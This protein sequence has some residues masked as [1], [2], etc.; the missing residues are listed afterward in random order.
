MNA[1]DVSESG[2]EENIWTTER[3]INRMEKITE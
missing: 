2:C 1:E 3:R